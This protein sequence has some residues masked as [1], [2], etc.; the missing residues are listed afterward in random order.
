MTSS[1]IDEGNVR[2]ELVVFL[3]NKDVLTITER[4]VTTSQDTG[5]FSAASSHTLATNP[6]LAKNVRDITVASS[7]LSFGTD[8]T[9]NYTT[10]L[11]TFVSNQTGAY[12]INYDQG[13]GDK[14]HPDFPRD[15]L[16]ISSY[17][18]IAVDT[19]DSSTEPLGIGGN[20][21]MT[22]VGIT[23]VAYA[24]TTKKIDTLITSIRE[25]MITNNQGFYYLKFVN[26]VGRGPLIKDPSSKK[27]IMSRSLDFL[28]KF[29]VE[30]IA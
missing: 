10:G 30:S 11:I 28:S 23:V 16:S 20:D 14:I 5:T 12:V 24:S 17:P 2:Q 4:G 9:V 27:E 22:E 1:F 21:Y 6:T 19:Q 18:R 25:D 29:N 13:S 15:D 3:R 7:A 8:Y 26:P